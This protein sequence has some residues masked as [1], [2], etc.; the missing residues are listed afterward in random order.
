M[1]E[2]GHAARVVIDKDN[3]VIVDGK[4]NKDRVTI[5]SQRC[6]E[7]LKQQ[8]AK[9]LK[10][11]QVDNADGIGPSLPFALGRKYPQAYRQPGWQFIFAST[12]ICRHPV[13]QSYCRH[14]L[15][16]SIMR[17]ALKQAV[18]KTSS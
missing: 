8:I 6:I 16:D 18:S 11:Q 9:A 12:T 15:H 4:G 3:T 13:S 10:L 1:A 2:L 7:P 14:H 5:L 17:K